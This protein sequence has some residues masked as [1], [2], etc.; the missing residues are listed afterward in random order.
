MNFIKIE[1][2]KKK[3][4]TIKNN[5]SNGYLVN[6]L[7]ENNL[8]LTLTNDS[9]TFQVDSLE[10]FENNKLDTLLLEK[11]IYD[12]GYQILYLKD[13]NLG[14]SYFSLSDLVI[15][16]RDIFLFINPNKLFTLL[17]KKDVDIPEIRS[18]QYGVIK[19]DS[20]D[21]HSLFLP[22]ELKEQ[23]SKYIYYTCAFYSLAKILLHI[24]NLDLEKLYYTNVYFF[25]KRCLEDKPELRYF[26]Y[27]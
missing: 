11:F 7:S 1:N 17:N 25:C 2:E 14:I 8:I 24:F 26:I 3:I 4:Y 10:S 22:P 20:I 21:K 18:Y 9:I 15:I 19:P 5:D 13:E 6:F 23:K 12:L 16:N 27:T